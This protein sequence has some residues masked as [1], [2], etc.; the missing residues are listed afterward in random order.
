MRID[1][2]GWESAGLRCPDVTVDLRIGKKVP[3]V[4]LIQMP[5]GTGKTTTLELLH[6]T[7]SGAAQDAALWTPDKVRKYRRSR[8]TVSKGR[9]KVTL[10]IDGKP[11]SIELSLDFESGQATYRS[12]SPGSGGVVPRWHVPPAVHRFL[13]A[14]FLNLFIFDGEFANRLLDGDYAEADR[15][16]DALCQLYLLDHVADFTKQFWERAS[17]AQGAKTATGLAR[18]QEY[19]AQLLKRQKKLKE[20]VIDGK[21]EVGDLEKKIAILDEKIRAR[22][23]S[24]TTTKQRFDTAQLEQIEAQAIVKARSADIMAAMRLPHALHP[25]LGVQL[26]ALRDNLDRLR[27]PEN[28]SAQFFEELVQEAECICGRPMDEHSI[29]EIRTRAKRYLDADD[30]GFINAL[31]SDIEQFAGPSTSSEEDSGY[32][33]VSRLVI[34]LKAAARTA[35]TAEDQLRA[36][37]QQL[38]DDGDDQLATWQKDFEEATQRHGAVEALLANIEA[39]G[40]AHEGEETQSLSLITKLL[41]DAKQKIAEITKTVQLRAETDLIQEL[42]GRAGKIARQRIKEEL[43][44]ESNARLLKVLANDPL[45]IERIDR[46]IRL[47]HQDGA[48]VGQ[49]LSVGYTFLMSVLSRGNND[50]PLVVDSPANPID[51]GVRRQIGR[52]V[53]QLCSQFVGFTINTERPGFVDTLESCAE[54][55]RFLT[56]FR[57]TPGTQRLMKNLP[58]GRYTE[59]GNAVLVDDKDYFYRFDV[60]D[61]EA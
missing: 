58:K 42:L 19:R 7:L 32:A 40:K 36:L 45:E 3:K 6:A 48:S 56:L 60:K 53:P 52:L 25:T 13:A 17:R 38:I 57:K 11:L 54:D 26:V 59:S 47:K 30:A 27:L 29:E 15:A 37:K 31:K 50:F 49:T 23:S 8:D 55:M 22:L 4:A 10:L 21:A 2:A 35:K 51:E 44:K 5:N 18:L 33:R 43:V 39:P 1:L 61:E 20:A 14:E 24:V 46:S 41:E 9:F 28:T 12:T 34:E 16:V